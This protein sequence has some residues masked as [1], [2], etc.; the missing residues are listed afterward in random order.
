MR[1]LALAAFPFFMKELYL[2]IS[3]I[4]DRMRDALVPM[5]ASALFEV[6]AAILGAHLGGISGLS[7]GWL[8][9]VCIEAALMSIFVYRRVW[10]RD[11]GFSMS[12]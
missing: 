5:V 12:E 9:A 11:P 6:V 8:I 4:Y 2:A 1:L 7:L 10:S 3:R